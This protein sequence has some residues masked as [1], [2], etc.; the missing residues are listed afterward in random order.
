MFSWFRL[1]YSTA[2]IPSLKNSFI[3]NIDFPVCKDCI[4]FIPPGSN[5][6]DY[7]LGKCGKF[8]EKD[9]VSGEIK[10]AFAEICRIYDNECGKN[11]THFESSD[12]SVNATRKI[13]LDNYGW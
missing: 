7:N 5:A 11:G 8:G 12:S 13:P 9:I 4:H 3:R 1:L 2:I 10:Y 6:L